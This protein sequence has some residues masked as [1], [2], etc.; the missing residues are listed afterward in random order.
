MKKILLP[1]FLLFFLPSTVWAFESRLEKRVVI[2]KEDVVEESIFVYADDFKMEGLVEGDIFCLSS[3]VEI[4][5]TVRG[6][7]ICLAE[8]FS[9]NGTSTGDVRVLSAKKTDIK[10]YIAGNLNLASAEVEVSDKS[11]LQGEFFLLADRADISGSIKKDFYAGLRDTSLSGK[12]GGDASVYQRGGFMSDR[13]LGEVLLKEGAVIEGDFFLSSEKTYEKEE[14]A[15][16]G[17]D[18]DF[19]TVKKDDSSGGFSLFWLVSKIFSSILLAFVLLGLFK[20]FLNSF[21]KN[22]SEKTW[23]SALIGA[24][25]FLAT[26]LLLFFLVVTII[27]LPLALIVLFLFVSLILLAK[28]LLGIFLGA[29][30]SKMLFPDKAIKPGLYASFGILLVYIILN[31]PLIGEYLNILA[32]FLVFGAFFEYCRDKFSK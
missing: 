15:Y 11:S 19:K 17:G 30:L 5:G 1:I 27:G 6:D 10:G 29:K 23:R 31:L 20:G 25:I 14:G 22:I 12:I 2:D 28:S 3:S 18:V 9:L 32:L 7:I 13:T 24:L 16:I 21:N 8:K 4:T 26:P